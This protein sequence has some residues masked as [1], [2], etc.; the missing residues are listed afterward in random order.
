MVPRITAGVWLPSER[1]QAILCF[2]TLFLLDI[3]Y[4]E[5]YIRIYK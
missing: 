3:V 5:H 4:I 1:E 2:V